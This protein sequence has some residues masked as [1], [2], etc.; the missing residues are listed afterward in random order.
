MLKC[1]LFAVTLFSLTSLMFAQ[2]PTA[3]YMKEPIDNRI[4]SPEESLKNIFVQPGYE[5]KLFAAEPHVLN[6]VVMRFD[7]FGRLWVVEMVGYMNDIRG[8]KELEPLGR[9][10]ILEDT[11]QDGVMDKPTIFLDKLIEPRAMAFH[12]DG[13]LWAD[14]KSLYFTKIIDG[15]KAGETILIDEK[16]SD[17]HSVEHKPNALLRGLDNWYYNAKCDKRYREVGGK[18]VI[19]RTEFRGQFGLSMDNYGRLYFGQQNTLLR[20]EMFT[21]NF[22]LRNPSLN[23][24][25]GGLAT[26]TNQI[27]DNC[28]NV[29][30]SDTSVYPNRLSNDI[31]DGYPESEHTEIDKN[32]MATN[33]T[34]ACSHFFY[35]DNYF[36]KELTAFVPDPALHIVKVITIERKDGIPSGKNTFKNSEIIA[37]PDT[38]F[39]PVDVQSAPDGTLYIAD[40]YHGILQHKVFMNDH[41]KKFISKNNLEERNELGRIYRLTVK[42]KK[43][44]SWKSFQSLTVDEVIEALGSENPW[45]RDSA[46][47]LLADGVYPNA[48]EKLKNYIEKTQSALGKVHGLWALE[49]LGVVE[50]SLLLKALSSSDTNLQIQAALIS[51][52]SANTQ[53]LADVLVKELGKNFSESTYYLVQRLANFADEK[54]QL[55]VAQAYTK[56]HEKPYF[57]KAILSG[58]GAHTEKWVESLADNPENKNLKLLY[59]NS[60]IVNKPAKESHLKG[61]D[62]AK[63]NKGVGIY[64]TFCFACHGLNGEGL[65]DMGPPLVLSEWVAGDKETL[66]SLVLKGMEGPITV[67]GVQYKP[68]LIMTPFELLLND[69]QVADVLTYV[70]NEWGNKADSVSADEVKEIRKKLVGRTTSFSEKD[71]KK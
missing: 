17:G 1:K 66:I 53:G 23:L 29:K 37:S 18:W 2:E 5:L 65:K 11:N 20:A 43:P 10:S 45:A 36:P 16:Y 58:G 24:R 9:I 28:Y 70:R 38:R 49:G 26:V 71:F 34:S 54:S 59:Q 39:R 47:R 4:F 31:R 69:Q 40:M 15:S 21:P 64:K 60:K 62:L 8:T 3:N 7:H 22:F 56:W 6:P 27:I 33:C 32:T 12:K 51:W 42:D 13:I 14:T 35:R 46:Q 52:K 30:V 67:K 19:E 50:E 63:F 41:L 48:V 61:D 44:N 68:T 55:A 57:K 25:T